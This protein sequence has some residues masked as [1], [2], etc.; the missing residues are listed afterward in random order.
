MQFRPEII[1]PK[2]LNFATISKEL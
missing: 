2:H 1:V